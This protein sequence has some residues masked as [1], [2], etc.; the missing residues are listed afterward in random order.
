[1]FIVKLYVDKTVKYGV[2]NVEFFSRDLS[3]N[4]SAIIVK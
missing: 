2:I 1:M 3:L 4:N